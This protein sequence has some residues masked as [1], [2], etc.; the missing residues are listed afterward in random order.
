VTAVG[1]DELDG[2]GRS[3]AGTATPDPDDD[4]AEPAVVEVMICPAAATVDVDDVTSSRV[5]T[6]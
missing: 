5:P 1:V 4:V 2:G 3:P 6:I